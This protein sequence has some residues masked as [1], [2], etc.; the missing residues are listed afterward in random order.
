VAKTDPH[1]LLALSAVQVVTMTASVSDIKSARSERELVTRAAARDS[2][3]QRELYDRHVDRVYRIAFRFAGD[4][5]AA[6]DITQETF[7]RA[8]GRLDEFRHEAALGTWLHTIAVS[9]AI[10]AMRKQSRAE[11]RHAPL[12]AAAH[13]GRDDNVADVDLR[14]RLYAAIDALPVGYRA[15]FVMYEMEG[16]THQEIASV[17]GVAE[18]T[19]K[20][21]LFR[22]RAKLRESLKHFVTDRRKA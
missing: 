9:V 11:R 15:V 16:Y 5:D 1:N 22:A 17:L 3:A 10:A 6:R 7:I 2:A 14:D 21:Q 20:G 12:D 13:I 4:D 18:T 8:F 19:S